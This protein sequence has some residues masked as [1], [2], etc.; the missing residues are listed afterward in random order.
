[1]AIN[2]NDS[3][4]AA[5]PLSQ[6]YASEQVP[7]NGKTWIVDSIDFNAPSTDSGWVALIWDY[8]GSGEQI[9]ELTYTSKTKAVNFVL[10][11]DGSKKLALVLHNESLGTLVMGGSY[12]AKEL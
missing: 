10:E 11:G 7:A 2:K 3:Y 1:M 4:F 6:E 12:T 8:Q 5:V 9:L